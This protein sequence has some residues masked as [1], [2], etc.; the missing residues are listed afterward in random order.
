[1]FARPLISCV[2]SVGAQTY[3]VGGE[4]EG[5]LLGEGRGWLCQSFLL[6]CADDAE[7]LGV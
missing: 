6:D 5:E 4:W 1:M 2:D 3:P 7:N